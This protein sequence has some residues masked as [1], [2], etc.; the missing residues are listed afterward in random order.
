MSTRAASWSSTIRLPKSSFPVRPLPA[1]HANFLKKCTDDYYAWQQ[2]AASP[3]FILHDG[4]PYA[5]GRLHIGHA[6][7]KILKDIICRV[8]VSDGRPVQ[9]IPGWDCH[10]LPI[11]LKALET[12]AA[13][14]TRD[15]GKAT[16]SKDAIS[17]RNA[18]RQLARNAVEEQK[19][20]FRSWAVM[21]D[22]GNAWTTMD[23]KFELKQLEVFQKM[24]QN[25]LINRRN[26]PVYWS[27]SSRTALAEAELEY[28][29]DHISL[30]TL[31]KLPLDERSP[32]R[33][34]GKTLH[35]LSLV[36]WT[37]T[38]W[39]L[40]ANMAVAFHRDME[41]M[42]VSSTSHGRL[43]ISS[44]R[45]GYVE[46]LID[47]EL[48]IVDKFSGSKFEKEPLLYSPL[49]GERS[50][51][52]PLIHANFVSPDTGTGLVHCAPG[53]GVEDYEALQLQIQSGQVTVTAPVDNKGQFTDDLPNDAK[54]LAGQDVLGSGT[55]SVI[56][57][58]EQEGRILA[59]QKY[60]HNYP[61]DWRTKQPVIVR[62]TSQWF[63]DVSN[64][65][66][67]ALNALE[68]VEFKP[69]S[70][71]NRLRSFVQNRSEWCISRQ[72]A[73]GLPIPAL[74]NTA[75]AEALLT[76]ETVSHIIKLL[77]ERGTDAWW[78]DSE[79]DDSWVAPKYRTAGVTYKRGSD[80]MDVWFDSGSSWLQLETRKK[81]GSVKIADAYVEGSDQHRGWFQ[82][83][84]LTYIA[85]WHGSGRASQPPYR[86]VITHGFTLDQHGK[87]MSKSI[88]NVVS[89]M[90]IINGAM[91]KSKKQGKNASLG[92]DMLRLWVASCDF[93]KDV[94]VSPTVLENVQNFLHKYRITFKL[95][96]GGLDDFDPTKQMVA[97]DRLQYVDQIALWQLYKVAS[98]V[99]QAYKAFE[100]HRGI[101]AINQWIV[102][103]L[104]ASYIESIKDRL[105]CSQPDGVTRRAVQSVLFNILFE[106]QA[107]LAPVTPLMV[108]EVSYY[109]S[110]PI[111]DC[112]LATRTRLEP[113]VSP[114]NHLQ[115][116][117]AWPYLQ[118]VNAVVKGVQEKARTE[119]RI[120]SSLESYV[121]IDIPVK[122]KASEVLFHAEVQQALRDMLVVSGLAITDGDGDQSSWRWSYQAVAELPDKTAVKVF[123][124]APPGSMGK[125]ARCWQYTVDGLGSGESDFESLCDR[126]RDVVRC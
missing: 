120:G 13:F 75:T 90:D 118:A 112:L 73:W 2:K 34:N 100:F 12:N 1:D 119:K 95:L 88:G 26:K 117:E 99:R 24:V 67:D 111:R 6:L 87:K 54:F 64:I 15:F 116:E 114:P 79:D 89:P 72:R 3:P 68:H 8:H 86:S 83:S 45:K 69:S 74:Y 62:A 109:S 94:T 65:R 52:K 47:D 14:T 57:F 43:I 97:Y 41:Y 48:E 66:Q 42:V 59:T 92:P 61:Y 102:S 106:M 121:Q 36:V 53:H 96:L 93:T 7:N 56:E 113:L 76:E 46:K 110:L 126:C 27:P 125:C 25:G 9:F 28:R 55:T 39:T 80:T 10:G 31:V 44:D 105:Y 104:S 91:N 82:S 101:A 108:E 30:S 123:V 19:G 81:S 71:K 32:L 58:L 33:V 63:A 4:P 84:L 21:G 17:I 122:S 49:F 20:E 37:T 70:G 78:S 115:I 124:H 103:D 60:Q 16:A 18:A 77:G 35:G 11:E 50:T 23:R 98:E 40:P 51:G 107:M 85:F 22:W 5:N 29:D 38:P